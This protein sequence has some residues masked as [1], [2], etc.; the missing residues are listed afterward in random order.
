MGD[1]HKCGL[2]G[3][4]MSVPD[5]V[6]VSCHMATGVL[7][8][9][10]ARD[11]EAD[12]VHRLRKRVMFQHASPAEPPLFTC[13]TKLLYSPVHYWT[14]T[15]WSAWYVG[16]WFAWALIQGHN[17]VEIRENI[18]QNNNCPEGQ[19]SRGASLQRG[20]SPDGRVSGR[21]S[22]QR[23]QSP[24]GPVSRGASLQ[25]GES[26]EGRVSRGASLQRGESPE[27]QVSGRASLQRGK[28][29]EGR[30]SGGASLQRASLR[31]GESP[32]GESPEGRVSDFAQCSL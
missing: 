10:C 12:K 2:R 22:L 30:V 19:V 20:E 7:Y 29:P 24:E 23:G 28:S 18:E 1:L 32:E 8:V 6:P 31:R 3:A 25:R 9:L 5:S 13:K 27:G 15:H 14:F 26:P 16:V 4:R 17:D 11:D 21:A